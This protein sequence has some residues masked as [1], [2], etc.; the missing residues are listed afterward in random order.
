MGSGIFHMKHLFTEPVA[1]LT[2]ILGLAFALYLPSTLL[3]HNEY[4][5]VIYATLAEKVAQRWTDYSLQGTPVLNELPKV[6]YDHP[7]FHRPPLF[8]YSLA[9]FRSLHP[10]AGPLLPIFSGIGVISLVFYLK[11]L[12]GGDASA[13]SAAAITALS[14]LLFFCSTR[15]LMDVLLTLGVTAVILSVSRAAE[16]ENPAGFAASGVLLGL[17][18]LAKETAILIVPACLYLVFRSG[19][20]SNKI[21]NTL[22]FFGTAFAVCFPWFYRFKSVMG[23]FFQQVGKADLDASIQMFPFMAQVVGRP[24]HFY[25]SHGILIAPI[26]AF[27]FWEM[28]RKIKEKEPLTETIWALTYLFGLTLYSLQGNG[29]QMRYVLPAIPAMSLLASDCASRAAPWARWVAAG[30]LSYG[31]WNGVM[32]GLLFKSP[33]VYPAFVFFR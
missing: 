4:D 3:P 8:V 7:I 6:T 22:I 32:N 11:R 27:A 30:C 12:S 26:G 29:Y 2:L 5:E 17:S 20:S 31:L 23:T 9:L 14:P 25:F 16:E 19:T 24:W 1:G 33:E 13:L 15:I 21:R 28:F 10:K 18:V